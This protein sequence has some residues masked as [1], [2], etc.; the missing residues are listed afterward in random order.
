IPGATSELKN[1]VIVLDPGHGG[2]DSGA[3]GG[4]YYE[5]NIVLDVGLQLRD[6]LRM[7]GALVYMT[8]DTDVFLSLSER[9]EYSNSIQ[10][11][12]FI[13]IHTNAAASSSATGLETFWNSVAGLLPEESNELATVL[14]NALIN[15]TSA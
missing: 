1:K 6:Y 7:R 2:H 12:A 13:S 5:K 15:T 11:D 14:Q 8:R 10:P 3:V 9:V 4:G